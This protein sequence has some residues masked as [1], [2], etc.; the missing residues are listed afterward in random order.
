[1]NNDLNYDTRENI[2]PYLSEEFYTAMD[3]YE[4]AQD[5]G[6]VGPVYDGDNTQMYWIKSG[7]Q[8]SA[9]KLHSDEFFSENLTTT[10]Q[11]DWWD[12]FSE[13]QYLQ[14]IM[15]GGNLWGMD[16]THH[17]IDRRLAGLEA[18]ENL[19][20]VFDLITKPARVL[21]GNDERS[22]LEAMEATETDVNYTPEVNYDAW[23]AANP[24]AAQVFENNGGSVEN[25][26]G[27]RNAE[28]FGYVIR[29]EMLNIA[30][31]AQANALANEVY[32]KY[33]MMGD[34]GL[35][36]AGFARDLVGNSDFQKEIAAEILIGAASGGTIPAI[37]RGV[38]GAASLL[39]AGKR[40]A[41]ELGKAAVVAGRNITPLQIPE[42]IAY[43]GI[44]ALF[45]GGLDAAEAASRKMFMGGMPHY[46]M[47][48]S[49]E[50]G[51]Y[52]AASSVVRQKADARYQAMATGEDIPLSMEMLR[53]DT[54]AGMALGPAFFLGFKGFGKALGS[55]NSGMGKGAAKLSKSL[56]K[57][58]RTKRIASGEDANSPAVLLPGDGASAHSYIIWETS[59]LQRAQGLLDRMTGGLAA[60][61][62]KVANIAS[63]RS[64][65][66]DPGQFADALEARYRSLPEGTRVNPVVMAEEVQS[67]V[68][69]LE[70]SLSK[71]P[72]VRAEQIRRR[73][74]LEQ[75]LGSTI[76]GAGRATSEAFKAALSRPVAAGDT[77]L[78]NFQRAAA[79]AVE[80]VTNGRDTRAAF[81]QLE[82]AAKKI[83]LNYNGKLQAQAHA[84]IMAVIKDIREN[85]KES[86]HWKS[87]ADPEARKQLAQAA[88]AAG[89]RMDRIDSPDDLA[90]ALEGIVTQQKGL[91]TGDS[92]IAAGEKLLGKVDDPDLEPTPGFN[93]Y[94]GMDPAARREATSRDDRLRQVVSVFT[95]N[96]K[97]SMDLIREI[98]KRM[99]P[100]DGSRPMSLDQAVRD[101]GEELMD[102]EFAPLILGGL[103]DAPAPRSIPTV[104]AFEDFSLAQKDFAEINSK[105]VTS[106]ML[107]KSEQDMVKER[108]HAT[109]W[110]E[111]DQVSFE[112][113]RENRINAFS[114]MLGRA[115]GAKELD[116]DAKLTAADIEALSVGI[117]E[118]DVP[119]NFKLFMGRRKNKRPSGVTIDTKSV[120]EVIGVLRARLLYEQSRDYKLRDAKHS[121]LMDIV[122]SKVADQDKAHGARLKMIGQ[123]KEAVARRAQAKFSE[124]GKYAGNL[125]REEWEAEFT[126][127]WDAAGPG[128]RKNYTDRLAPSPSELREMAHR[129]GGGEDALDYLTPQQFMDTLAEAWRKSDAVQNKQARP[130]DQSIKLMERQRLHELSQGMT[131]I[132]QILDMSDAQLEKIGE[133]IEGAQLEARKGGLSTTTVQRLSSVLGI[134]ER[135]TYGL[136]IDGKIQSIDDLVNEVVAASQKKPGG[137]VH[138]H[139]SRMAASMDDFGLRPDLDRMSDQ[140]GLTLGGPFLGAREGS[141]GDW[142]NIAF[143][144]FAPFLNNLV[145]ASDTFRLVAG[146]NA[147]WKTADGADVDLS[148]V[149]EDKDGELTITTT[150]AN[151]NQMTAQVTEKPIIDDKSQGGMITEA[152]RKVLRRKF[153]LTENEPIDVVKLMT[154]DKFKAVRDAAAFDLY[155]AGMQKMIDGADEPL[156]SKLIELKGKSNFRGLMKGLFA[157][158][159][160][161]QKKYAR[162]DTLNHLLGIEA[163]GG[164]PEVFGKFKDVMSGEE[165]RQFADMMFDDAEGSVPREI[166]LSTAMDDLSGS[167]LRSGR[168][169]DK[170]LE[171]GKKLADRLDIPQDRA[172]VLGQIAE[173]AHVR[174]ITVDEVL[175]QMGT[176]REKLKAAKSEAEMVTLIDRDPFMKAAEEVHNRTARKAADEVVKAL[177][178]RG[179]TGYAKGVSDRIYS[180]T[181]RDYRGRM[182]YRALNEMDPQGAKAVDPS[183]TKS[184]QATSTW[185][186]SDPAVAKMLENNNLL[187]RDNFQVDGTVGE[188]TP[189]QARR[190]VLQ[191]LAFKFGAHFELP[192][193]KTSNYSDFLAD[194]GPLGFGQM[195][196]VT[197][198][199]DADNSLGSPAIQEMKMRSTNAVHGD[200]RWA[201]A[202]QHVNL[203]GKQMFDKNG[204]PKSFS[205]GS[206]EFVPASKLQAPPRVE[207][208]LADESMRNYQLDVRSVES[209]KQ[210]LEIELKTVAERYGFELKTDADIRRAYALTMMED[211]H[212]HITTGNINATSKVDP[213]ILMESV[214][215][216]DNTF[217]SR[218]FDILKFDEFNNLG[219]LKALAGREMPT[220]VSALLAG[221]ADESNNLGAVKFFADTGKA[222][223]DPGFVFGQG[224]FRGGDQDTARMA[225]VNHMTDGWMNDFM[226][227]GWDGQII[228]DRDGGATT[229]FPFTGSQMYT[230]DTVL[231][232]AQLAELGAGRVQGDALRKG[233]RTY[234]GRRVDPTVYRGSGAQPVLTMDQLSMM[235]S[236]SKN[237]GMMDALLLYGLNQGRTDISVNVDNGL[238]IKTTDASGVD[239][240][241]VTRRTM[242]LNE[243]LSE[244]LPVSRD[245]KSPV[246]VPGEKPGHLSTVQFGAMKE[247][248]EAAG[249]EFYAALGDGDTATGVFNTF[250]RIGTKDADATPYARSFMTEIL[251]MT[252]DDVD[253][254]AAK[255]FSTKDKPRPE[256]PEVS[257]LSS[258]SRQA[259]ESENFR[260]ISEVHGDIDSQL[261]ALV[262]E[263]RQY[264]EAKGLPMELV[265]KLEGELAVLR[266]I[267]GHMDPE[268]LRGTRLGSVS[269]VN[270]LGQAEPFNGKWGMNIANYFETGDMSAARILL[271]E[272]GHVWSVRT[273]MEEGVDDL[274]MALDSKAGV[275]AVSGL[276]RLMGEMTGES[277][278]SIRFRIEEYTGGEK[279]INE[280][281]AEWFAGYFLKDID[282]ADVLNAYKGLKSPEA[283]S[284]FDKLL[285]MIT[286]I[287]VKVRDTAMR[288][289]ELFATAEGGNASLKELNDFI[290]RTTGYGPSTKLMGSIEST[291]HAGEE[292]AGDLR[293]IERRHDDDVMNMM[294]AFR[295]DDPNKAEFDLLS[296]M[297]EAEEGKSVAPEADFRYDPRRTEREAK[298]RAN[299][300]IEQRGD[301][302]E[303]EKA[304]IRKEY[305]TKAREA[306]EAMLIGRMERLYQAA[307]TDNVSVAADAHF[308]VDYLDG[309]KLGL[310][311]LAVDI[312]GTGST[313]LADNAMV[314]LM[315]VL[316]ASPRTFNTQFSHT[317][318]VPNFYVAQQQA[319]QSLAV[320]TDAI[321]KLNELAGDDREVMAIHSTI[322]K[323]IHQMD[324]KL[325][326]RMGISPEAKEAAKEVRTAMQEYFRGEREIAL[327]AETPDLYNWGAEQGLANGLL[328]DESV[329]RPVR[330]ESDDPEFGLIIRYTRKDGKT[331]ELKSVEDARK[332][333]LEDDSYTPMR[334]SDA[335]S[336]DWDQ[337]ALATR[338]FLKEKFSNRNRGLSRSVLRKSILGKLLDGDLDEVDIDG[339]VI[340]KDM[341]DLAFRR[342]DGLDATRTLDAL[343]TSDVPAV[344][345]IAHIH[346]GVVEGDMNMLDPVARENVEAKQASD[347]DADVFDLLVDEVVDNERGRRVAGSDPEDYNNKRGRNSRYGRDV[348]LMTREDIYGRVK[349]DES[350]SH[351]AL[352]E[353][354]D[355]DLMA[356]LMTYSREYGYKNRAQS[357]VKKVTGITGMDHIT[358]VDHV[359]KR[360]RNNT[361][362]TDANKNMINGIKHKL[363]AFHAKAGGAHLAPVDAVSPVLD[364][365]SRGARGLVMLSTGPGLGALSF[366]EVAFNLLDNYG[367][368]G[369]FQNFTKGLK[370]LAKSVFGG[371]DKEQTAGMIASLNEMSGGSADRIMYESTEGL[372]G[373]MGTPT[374]FTWKGRLKRAVRTTGAGIRGEGMS[375]RSDRVATAIQGAGQV[376]TE[377]GGLPAV[378]RLARTLSVTSMRR[379]VVNMITDDSSKLWKLSAELQEFKKRE[380]RDPDTKEWQS[381]ARSSGWGSK[382]GFALQLQKYGL[383]D[384]VGLTDL[385]RGLELGTLDE[386]TGFD[387]V[388]MARDLQRT[389]NEATDPVARENARRAQAAVER[390]GTSTEEM[391]NQ[392]VT[393]G[394]GIDDLGLSQSYQGAINR[395]AFS[396]M[397]FTMNF[398]N[399]RIF[400]TAGQGVGRLVSATATYIFAETMIRLLREEARDHDRFIEELEQDPIGTIVTNGLA[401]YP[402]FGMWSSLQPWMAGMVRN[403][404]A[405]KGMPGVSDD[406]E[407][408]R[409]FDP[410]SFGAPMSFANRW[411]QQ[412]GR[413]LDGDM[414]NPMWWYDTGRLAGP[415]SHPLV[416]TGLNIGGMSRTALRESGQEGGEQ[417]R[418]Q[419]P[420]SAPSVP[421][422]SPSS[423]TTSMDV[424]P[425]LPTEVTKGNPEG[426]SRKTERTEDEVSVVTGRPSEAAPDSLLE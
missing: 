144:T 297:I 350:P 351:T 58:N 335:T 258:F 12:A 76:S 50:G 378:T 222:P 11:W 246:R 263:A 376:A 4:S 299:I 425:V 107:T 323:S 35:T 383:L 73:G 195:A 394:Y 74:R 312:F 418:L 239:P 111:K 420:T 97:Y 301:L 148:K 254:G 69:R 59:Q 290:G 208:D 7:A 118:G 105:A 25:V 181:T 260:E 391:M 36:A 46:L 205:P 178:E 288:M 17:N 257:N 33:G 313:D 150:D 61:S 1:M 296:K 151:G 52:M 85:G 136:L 16:P 358:F 238:A 124:S 220:S 82:K 182:Y 173:I 210:L 344:R 72:N 353:M 170:V 270:V 203:M 379:N 275:E 283:K 80:A 155:I 214:I 13:G 63:L 363:H 62:M 87:Y 242:A 395:V 307:A 29:N 64:K 140:A 409:P 15:A 423:G 188:L 348:D 256:I 200:T 81:R 322:L 26:K 284:M 127:L 135:A 235:T 48:T 41:K 349:R 390:F 271:H 356:H 364:N 22:G 32:G 327:E 241:G 139:D 306:E 250:G 28:Q 24:M 18:T 368:E 380:G 346:N 83:G 392:R 359:I 141:L 343:S 202:Q 157:G 282:E 244:P 93:E 276:I 367:T 231:D 104:S 310:R 236:L 142:Y 39:G 114:S 370:V 116:P 54:M 10:R 393:E 410:I 172:L 326:D 412:F 161:G 402:V 102:D 314:R 90:R 291:R 345:M 168:S 340:T 198:G 164:H 199:F 419:P 355:T 84:D 110:D 269:D 424:A 332:A 106:K 45:G 158:G 336:R 381:M 66:I 123:E 143:E 366:C 347:R 152:G 95:A 119:F 224:F 53:S 34:Y 149:H 156:K 385:R 94:T 70:G 417:S 316:H 278:A 8:R 287:A 319:A 226:M 352:R 117:M 259:A 237:A 405:Y 183:D 219:V 218:M 261:L 305:V 357:I 79:A 171:S 329:Y 201:K 165:A 204:E 375:G 308:L 286:G 400:N 334:I 415:V 389:I 279:D 51:A 280:M 252:E 92:L 331:I 189:K 3:W 315:A 232:A 131:M 122:R 19:P 71:D 91:L 179:W 154:D 245:A 217:G 47:A 384:P 324:E 267:L 137:A 386:L 196:E 309:D 416:Y 225:N 265:T 413:A 21:A 147:V 285:S 243:L 207:S 186:R 298:E 109:F 369:W 414:G 121:D 176:S 211:V 337:F 56:E 404:D 98:Y 289:R 330:G 55:A 215:A 65:G 361:K 177:E 399:Q 108:E 14:G 318:G 163:L 206:G 175:S 120:D 233:V 191:H 57:R 145:Q 30:N 187:T 96:P 338:D 268:F 253:A 60:A 396:L 78:R 130:L 325:I 68:T 272:L 382:W 228:Y 406:F 304:S 293:N 216:G 125:T 167:F 159:Q 421:M 407:A 398:A 88:K 101:V 166:G 408:R 373:V 20:G 184:I 162:I 403:T 146:P 209:E 40:T 292:T 333:F 133:Q 134:P 372:N 194:D 37:Y 6:S 387:P 192:G 411:F 49:L 295:G 229:S 129:F 153:G 2:G 227:L 113:S 115:L 23:K 240:V 9:E 230:T 103:T 27:T 67:I 180:R 99:E 213:M 339:I 303:P 426:P 371:L 5:A 274:V 247:D 342:G 43:K 75:D 266:Q 77:H 193:L 311:S 174:G 169:L 112:R 249:R 401:M 264:A 281:L 302:S 262:D 223:Y 126:R 89:I 86:K 317:E 190:M 185:R 197:Q 251:G 354:Y 255:F 277:E 234:D 212:E 328:F 397:S 248:L 42:A 128:A 38:K 374:D 320:P 360:L 132:E 362:K 138:T 422:S 294:I 100:T 160:Y 388:S 273:M 31:N 377:L 321:K 341:L 44:P 300:A 221:F 365:V